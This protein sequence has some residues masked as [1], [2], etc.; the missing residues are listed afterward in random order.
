MAASPPS[1]RLLIF[2]ISSMEDTAPDFPPLTES[3]KNLL[4]ELEYCIKELKTEIQGLPATPDNLSQKEFIAFH[5]GSGFSLL[6]RLHKELDNLTVK[7]IRSL[8]WR[9]PGQKGY[10]G[11]CLRFIED[12]EGNY[13]VSYVPGDSIHYY[14]GLPR[15]ALEYFCLWIHEKRL[16]R[17]DVDYYLLADCKMG[18]ETGLKPPKDLV[19]LE[20]VLLA[21]GLDYSEK[22]I[23][24][25]TRY[26][27]LAK[28]LKE[29]KSR[30]GRPKKRVRKVNKSWDQIASELAEVAKEG[31]IPTTGESLKIM[32]QKM[33]PE[34]DFD[35]V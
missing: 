29:K 33:F 22:V 23:E 3:Q 24:K 5:E 15:W 21:R 8:F 16:M 13:E 6:R 7:A 17:S 20:K 9:I 12:K 14:P 1:G 26:Q 27:P 35:K 25:L 4:E 31:S 34:I 28:K 30:I 32:L 11:I 10:P 19:L 18:L 2:G